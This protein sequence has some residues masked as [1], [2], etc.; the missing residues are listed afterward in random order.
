MGLSDA[1]FLR[2]TL[3][4]IAPADIENRLALARLAIAEGTPRLAVFALQKIPAAQVSSSGAYH[5]LLGQTEHALGNPAG[6]DTEFAEA[7]RLE[8]GNA[9][10]RLNLNALRLSASDPT[11]ARHACEELEKLVSA[12]PAADGALAALLA[13]ALAHGDAGRVQRFRQSLRRRPNRELKFDLLCLAS[14]EGTPAFQKSLDSVCVK[15]GSK[16]G[17]AAM[18]IRWL[19]S[20]RLARTAITWDAALSAKVRD[21]IAVRAAIADAYVSESDWAGLE[22]FLAAQTW[23]EEDFV[24]RAILLRA[25]SASGKANLKVGWLTLMD[26]PAIGSP[27]LLALADLARGWGCGAEEEAACW[28]VAGNGMPLRGEALNRLWDIYLRAE[29]PSDL[30]RV[31][32][33]RLSDSPDDIAARNN[34]AF[35]SLLLGRNEAGTVRLARENWSKAPRRTEV[36]A[37]YGYALL[38]GGRLEESLAVFQGLKAGDRERPNVAL[39]YALALEKAGRRKE[40]SEFAAF[41]TGIGML[42]EERKLLDQLHKNLS[43]GN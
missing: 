5:D 43:R 38:Q 18:L 29:K 28:R 35:L 19:T 13:D 9:T 32:K 39:Y 37:T 16:P 11:V 23:Q 33:A 8:P 10:F 7:V 26:E 31:A 3:E 27:Q 36:A 40:A 41:V 34:V 14:E 1:A 22:S 20:H 21:V 2:I 15:A 42:A 30:L 12:G 17:D 25:R 24:R 6:A 4:R